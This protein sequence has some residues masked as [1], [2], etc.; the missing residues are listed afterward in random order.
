MANDITQ[1]KVRNYRAT[2]GSFV[3]GYQ[4]KLTMGVKLK[5]KEVKVGTLGDVVLDERVIGLTGTIKIEFRQL[6]AAMRN[7]LMPW[8]ATAGTATPGTAGVSIPMIPAAFHTGLYQYA[9]ELVLHPVDLIDADTSQDV[10][11]TKAVPW[12]KEDADGVA[13]N[14]LEVEFMIYPDQSQAT[15][16]P[17]VISYGYYGPPPG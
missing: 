5:T 8:S 6:S 14:K 12:I 16:S 4:D 11:F 13:D 9:K 3:G 1:T 7:G 10:T 15:A 17:P 2:W